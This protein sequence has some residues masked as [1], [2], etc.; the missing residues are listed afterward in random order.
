MVNTHRMTRVDSEAALSVA[1]EACTRAA[2]WGGRAIPDALRDVLGGGSTNPV[3]ARAHAN[4]AQ[5]GPHPA[6]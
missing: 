5:A 2:V 4:R 3:W 1:R 6:H